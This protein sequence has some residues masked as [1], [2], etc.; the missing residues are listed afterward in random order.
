MKTPILVLLL[1][2]LVLTLQGCTIYPTHASGSVAVH[3]H[4]NQV[5]LRFSDYQRRYIEHYYGHPKPQHYR[6]PPSYYQRY[7]QHERLP[8]QYRPKPISR[9][10]NRHFP[11]LP[12]GYARVMIG[13]DMAIMNTRTRVLSDIIWQ[14]R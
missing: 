10:L 12:K 7:H 14:I 1:G 5:N 4:H 8:K 6:V 3:D 13:N 9:D 2:T 11:S